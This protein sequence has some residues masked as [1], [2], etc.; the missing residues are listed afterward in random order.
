LAGS[1][2][3]LDREEFVLEMG[4]SGVPADL[5]EFVWDQLLPYY[6]QSLGPHP[7]DR[8]GAD[9]V[10]DPDD[11]TDIAIDYEKKFRRRFF[12]NP[13]DCPADSSVCEFAL[14]LHRGSV[15]EDHG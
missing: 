3:T 4:R 12:N 14:S 8:I 13:I 9:L 7:S 10:I 5:A 1:R 2:P 6:T 15:S 11:L